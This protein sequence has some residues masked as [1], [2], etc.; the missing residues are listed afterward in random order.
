MQPKIAIAI[1]ERVTAISVIV[2]PRRTGNE[3]FAVG[4]FGVVNAFD[5]VPPPRIFVDLVENQERLAVRKLF[6]S[7]ARGNGGVVPVVI[8]RMLWRCLV[9]KKP[10]RQCGLARLS[11][12][13]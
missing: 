5:E 6:L 13:T 11:W 7:N 8:G 1:C 9:T 3:D 10:Q 2:E 4:M 12:S